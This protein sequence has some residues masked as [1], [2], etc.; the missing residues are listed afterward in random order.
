MPIANLDHMPLTRPAAGWRGKLRPLLSVGVPVVALSIIGMHLLSLNHDFAQPSAAQ[1][2]DSSIAAEA[3]TALVG[4]FG[5]GSSGAMAAVGSHV[6]GSDHEPCA[7]GCDRHSSM[8]AACVL[9]F[10]L[11][12]VLRRL[13]PGRPRSMRRAA[14]RVNR[15]VA[16]RRTGRRVP[17]L[18]LVE[19]SVRRT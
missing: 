13:P 7:G 19:L 5:V 6:S 17:A 10:A 16:A 3:S 1:R 15:R 8:L 4:A 2:L 11:L 14:T 12:I 18:S 9:A